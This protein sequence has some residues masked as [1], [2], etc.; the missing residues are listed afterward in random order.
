M[1]KKKIKGWLTKR[2]GHYIKKQVRWIKD[3]CYGGVVA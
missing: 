3:S 2:N 1:N